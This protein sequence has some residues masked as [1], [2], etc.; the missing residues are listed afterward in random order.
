VYLSTGVGVFV[1]RQRVCRIGDLLLIVIMLSS[2]AHAQEDQVH[3]GEHKAVTSLHLSPALKQL[4]LQ[5]MQ[6]VEQGMMSLIPAIAS[7]N[8]EAIALVGKQIKDSYIIKQNLTDAQIREL[9]HAV[10]PAFLKLDQSFHKAA[11]MLA[12]AAE[13]KNA[14]V[15]NFYFYKLNDACVQCHSQFASD[16]FPGLMMPQGSTGHK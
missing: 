7:G 13:M 9:H 15:V 4:L 1:M 2:C 11:G 12:H 3:L 10:P 16:K 5:E 6:A 14:D 8:W